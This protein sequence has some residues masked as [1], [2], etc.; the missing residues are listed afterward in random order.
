MGTDLRPI[1]KEFFKQ[2]SLDFDRVELK[3]SSEVSLGAC[4]KRKR[5]EIR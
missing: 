3:L 5:E 2:N 1:L 4:V